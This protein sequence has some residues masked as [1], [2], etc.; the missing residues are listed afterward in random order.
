[1]DA[2]GKAMSRGRWNRPFV[3]FGVLVLSA[4]TGCGLQGVAASGPKIVA[5]PNPVPAG[6]GKGSTKISWDIPDRS[7][8]EVYVSIDGAP[9]QLFAGISSTGTQ[10][11]DWIDKGSTYEFRLYQ[12][13]GHERVLNRVTVT[14]GDQ[15]E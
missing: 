8:G 13:K 7:Q 3:P 4:L 5:E 2:G 10:T 12:G 6:P 15:R 11:A 14:R 9:E 1:M